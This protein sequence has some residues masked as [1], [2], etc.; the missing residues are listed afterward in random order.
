[1]TKF[2]TLQTSLGNIKLELDDVKAPISVGNFLEYV[3]DGFYDGVI[4]HRVIR[5][6]MI[7]AGGFEPGMKQKTTKTEIQNESKNGLKNDKYAIAMARTSAPHS[8]TSQFFINTKDNDF[9]NMAQSVDAWGYA[10]FGKVVEGQD[11]VDKIELVSTGRQGFH[12]DVPKEDIVIFKAEETE[13]QVITESEV[14]DLGS[15]LGGIDQL[16]G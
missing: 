11:T 6:F 13:Q 16:A 10:V 4:F 8:A 2:V 7:Q 12:D 9:L 14:G 1:M 5:N 3:R 15:L